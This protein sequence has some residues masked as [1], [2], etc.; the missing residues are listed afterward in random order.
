MVAPG[1]DPSGFFGS[2]VSLDAQLTTGSVKVN[3]SLVNVGNPL[4]L[5]FI[6]SD[7]DPG[8]RDINP[9]ELGHA[10]NHIGDASDLSPA[11]ATATYTFTLN[12]PYGRDSNGRD[13]FTSITPDQ[14]QRV[15]EVFEFYSKQLGIDFTE[16]ASPT[17]NF[18]VVVG[19]MWPNGVTSRPGGEAGVAGGDLAIMDGAERGITISA[20]ASSASLCTKSATCSDW[21]TPTTCLQVRPWVATI[22]PA[23][24]VERYTRASSLATTMSCTVSSYIALT[25]K[26][27]ICI[28]SA[29]VLVKPGPF[30]IETIAERLGQQQQ[31]GHG[32][33]PLQTNC[34]WLNRSRAQ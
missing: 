26:T 9:T 28:V 24:K 15:R 22:P 14:M 25:T 2:A 11:I 7:L 16:T 20:A 3:E 29:S 27:S 30:R 6:G 4:P 23:A 19:D 5:D 18:R 17:A 12:T 34:I 1:T 32:Y 21:G 8:N 33:H 13:V 10:D 31:R